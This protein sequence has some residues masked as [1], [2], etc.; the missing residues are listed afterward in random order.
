MGQMASIKHDIGLI[1]HHCVANVNGICFDNTTTTHY[2]LY[3]MLYCWPLCNVNEP[4]MLSAKWLKISV[5]K[6]V[7]NVRL[8]TS[9]W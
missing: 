3:I 4:D 5:P 7:L 9:S 1:S 8:D 2:W 6:K